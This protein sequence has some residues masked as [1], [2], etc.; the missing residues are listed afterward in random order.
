MASHMVLLTLTLC[1]RVNK[2]LHYYLSPPPRKKKR[3]KKKLNSVYGTW[4]AGLGL[5][6]TDAWY[7]IET[8]AEKNSIGYKQLVSQISFYLIHHY[9]QMHSRTVHINHIIHSMLATSAIKKSSKDGWLC[10]IVFSWVVLDP[11]N[12]MHNVTCSLQLD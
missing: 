5:P 8:I 12:C 9:L 10:I 1:E 3:E 6:D 11:V 2:T 7:M 4:K